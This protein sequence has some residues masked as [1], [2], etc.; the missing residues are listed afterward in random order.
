MA[1][2]SRN[3]PARK[4]VKAGG[5]TT[6]KKSAAAKSTTKKAASAKAKARAPKRAKATP[7]S[8]EIDAEVLEFIEA[9]DKYKQKHSRPFPSWS[10]V[11]MVLKSL[12]YAKD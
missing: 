10:E 11:L 7:D 8:A 9:I 1:S 3:S 4:A 5:K 12:G 2:S 6:E